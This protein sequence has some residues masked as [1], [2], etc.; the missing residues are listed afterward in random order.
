MKW[1]GDEIEFD[2]VVDKCSENRPERVVQSFL[3]E[4]SEAFAGANEDEESLASGRSPSTR[5][6]VE[7]GEI[8]SLWNSFGRKNVYRNSF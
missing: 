5:K 8:I 6:P 4:E 2:L 3:C 7:F 1:I